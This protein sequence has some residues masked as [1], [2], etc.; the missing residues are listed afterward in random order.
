MHFHSVLA[1]AKQHAK[2]NTS[3]NTTL[4][5]TLKCLNAGVY[6]VQHHQP[7]C[8]LVEARTTMGINVCP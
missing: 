4:A 1:S 5:E 3:A 8:G 2:V 6:S 7:K